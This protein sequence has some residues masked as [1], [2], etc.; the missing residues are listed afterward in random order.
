MYS[1]V[2]NTQFKVKKKERKRN[3]TINEIRKQICRPIKRCKMCL[4]NNARQLTEE[5][6]RHTHKWTKRKEPTSHQV[7]THQEL[8]PAHHM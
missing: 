4:V 2:K 1:V 6:N 3:I 7:L 8:V 5:Y